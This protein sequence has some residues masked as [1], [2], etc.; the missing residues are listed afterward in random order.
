MRVNIS[1]D[2]ECLK[3]LDRQAKEENRTRSSQIRELIKKE[4][5]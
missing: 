2:K 1:I 4:R 5:K 3:E